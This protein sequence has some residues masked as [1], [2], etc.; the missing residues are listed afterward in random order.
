M[1]WWSITKTLSRL[2][3]KFFIY[4]N[5]LLDKEITAKSKRFLRWQKLIYVVMLLQTDEN[6]NRKCV[7]RS[8]V[9]T[10]NWQASLPPN[11]IS[12]VLLWINSMT[13]EIPCMLIFI[14]SA[15]KF[16]TH[17][18]IENITRSR[19]LQ[20]PF[21]VNLCSFLRKIIKPCCIKDFQQVCRDYNGSTYYSIR[22]EIN[23]KVYLHIISYTKYSIPIMLNHY[24]LDT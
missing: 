21:I 12:W 24:I 18:V 9:G 13:K 14:F 8:F 16:I 5:V 10:V 6:D 19:T 22:T 11:Q 15:F 17:F 1:H 2:Q 20:H 3:P 23:I 4:K 7:N